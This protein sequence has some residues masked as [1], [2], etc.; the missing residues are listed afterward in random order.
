MFPAF[1]GPLGR[2]FDE[3]VHGVDGVIELVVF[4][5]PLK[6]FHDVRIAQSPV[7]TTF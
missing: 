5:K 6:E 2:I 7:C 4:F 1:A 3:D